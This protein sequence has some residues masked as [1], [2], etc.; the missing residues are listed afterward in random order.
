M[1]IALV[2]VVVVVAA[3]A[4]PEVDIVHLQEMKPSFTPRKGG[5]QNC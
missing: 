4:E 5:N 2:V 1:S 3:A